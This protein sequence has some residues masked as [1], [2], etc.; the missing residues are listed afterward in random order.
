MTDLFENC[1]NTKKQ[2]NI[3]IG[4][5]IAWFISNNYT[6][7]IPINDSQE[8]DLVVEKDSKLQSVQVKTTKGI[9][10]SG[11]YEVQLK[12]AGGSSGKVIKTFETSQVDLLFILCSNSDKYLIPRVDITVSSKLTL[13]DKYTQYKI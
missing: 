11:N 13:G 6:V 8:Y 10:L 4:Y 1:I 12:Q 5:A 9:A 3:G 2:G 7:S